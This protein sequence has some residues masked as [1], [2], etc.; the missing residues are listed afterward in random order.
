LIYVSNDVSNAVSVFRE[1]DLQ[2]IATIPV[3][4][5]PL[6]VAVA[7]DGHTAVVGNDLGSS[8]SLIATGTETVVATK[9]V[10]TN[11]ARVAITP[12]STKAVVANNT[13]GTVSIVPLDTN[14]VDPLPTQT[15]TLLGAPS[16]VAIT[17]TPFF[18]LEK[19]SS[20]E[21]VAAGSTVVYKISYQNIGSGPGV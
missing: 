6:S 11:P 10:G 12:D 18:V 7:P 15:I 2:P 9:S 13:D 19:T 8:I 3:G 17:P 1:I 21:V 4:A 14:T 5:S 20:P 16:S